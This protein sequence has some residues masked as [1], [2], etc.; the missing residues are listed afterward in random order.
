VT[1][2]KEQAV[3]KMYISVNPQGKTI[4]ILS[5]AGPSHRFNTDTEQICPTIK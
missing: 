3:Q 1:F 4:N 2:E 5:Q